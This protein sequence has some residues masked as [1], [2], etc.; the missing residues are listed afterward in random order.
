MKKKKPGRPRLEN[1]HSARL[2]SIRVTKAQQRAYREAAEAAGVGF[3]EWVRRV[4]DKAS[5]KP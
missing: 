1:G 2:P 3:G 5:R 4:L